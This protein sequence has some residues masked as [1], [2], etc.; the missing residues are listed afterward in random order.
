MSF[1]EKAYELDSK[2]A[3]IL[4]NLA[5]CAMYID[6]KISCYRYLK[7]CLEIEPENEEAKRLLK[8]VTESLN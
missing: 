1:L 3:A 5:D 7:L 8:V 6:R 2:N 4:I